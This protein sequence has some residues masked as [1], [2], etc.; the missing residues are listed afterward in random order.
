[1]KEWWVNVYDVGYIWYGP[2][3]STI[4][5]AEFGVGRL[6]SRL[7]YRIHVRLK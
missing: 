6:T 7:L 4:T 3:H 2:R 1:M 5:K